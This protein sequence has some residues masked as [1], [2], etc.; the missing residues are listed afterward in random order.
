M[1]LKKNKTDGSVLPK[2]PPSCLKTP[3]ERSAY[4]RLQDALSKSALTAG[5]DVEAVVLAARRLAYAEELR[6]FVNGLAMSERFVR[7][8]NGQPT[9]HPALGVLAAAERDLLASLRSLLLTVAGRSS[10]R[11]AAADLEQAIPQ[12]LGTDGR[13]SSVILR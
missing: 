3:G 5:C 4:S 6:A 1:P 13:P 12:H 7:G 2:R 9:P 8:G 10:S 11:L